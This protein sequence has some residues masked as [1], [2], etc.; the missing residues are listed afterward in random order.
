MHTT[1]DAE[2]K[3]RF[4]WKPVLLSVG[5]VALVAVAAFVPQTLIRLRDAKLYDSFQPMANEEMGGSLSF[6][7]GQAQAIV[8]LQNVPRAFADGYT[9]IELDAQETALQ[10]DAAFVRF[11]ALADAGIAPAWMPD[12]LRETR[13][14]WGGGLRISRWQKEYENIVYTQIECS[15]PDVDE[16]NLFSFTLADAG[17]ADEKVLSFWVG[18]LYTGGAG[19]YNMDNA[20]RAYADLLN[21]GSL[22]DWQFHSAYEDD[23]QSAGPSSLP[24]E[25][26]APAIDAQE[27]TGEIYWG[28]SM[29][30]F[31]ANVNLY[32]SLSL[33]G[34][35]FYMHMDFGQVTVM[36]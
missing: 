23:V 33:Y 24:A 18:C 16:T 34:D 35:S 8:L 1:N 17:G 32:G 21:L 15:L 9:P 20:L 11:D 22:E 29:S 25:E 14:A 10:L 30:S 13:D 27:F 5:C 2:R 26:M 28:A 19:G 12:A 31:S 7:P 4:R 3:R 36:S 6:T